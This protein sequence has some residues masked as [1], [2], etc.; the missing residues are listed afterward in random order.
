MDSFDSPLVSPSKA[1]Q[2]AMK[3]KDWAY[4]NS[5]LIRQYAP[6][7][8]PQYER[9]EDTLRVLL[10]LA[11]ANDAAD[12]EAA[13]QHRAREEAIQAFKAQAE[14][15]LKDPH[16]RLKNEILDEVEMCLDDKGRRDLDDLAQS[17][18]VLGSTLNPEPMHL[19]QSIVELT[20]EDFDAQNQVTKVEAIQSYLQKELV[21]LQEYL[22]FLKSREVY[23]TPQDI[24]SMTA[25][26]N[27][28]TKM[29]SKKVE[30]YQD[31]IVSL[32]RI[33]TQGP[34]IEDLKREEDITLRLRKEVDS[35]GRRIKA[36]RNL[37]STIPGARATYKELEGELGRLKRQR[38][39][40][41]GS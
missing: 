36:F 12:E 39:N 19:S 8:V 22:E 34:S 27:R 29:L 16:E 33:Q 25:D 17:A 14:A 40:I 37:P 41:L 10:T 30:E 15:E 31:R 26:W 32:E 38:D 28:N 4:V 9:N 7:P 11:A 20:V 21:R 23:E 3:A 13:L 2:A 18:A 1:R 5:W 24:Q 35:L 6:K